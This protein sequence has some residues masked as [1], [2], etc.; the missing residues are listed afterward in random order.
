MVRGLSLVSV[1]LLAGLPGYGQIIFGGPGIGGGYPG[2]RYPQGG[3][4]GPNQQGQNNEQSTLVGTLRNLTE[5]NL[6]IEDDDKNVTVVTISGSTK[7]LTTS[8]AKTDSGDFQPGDRISIN[9]KQDDKTK[10]YKA[11]EISMVRVGT[12]DEHSLASL[13]TDDMAPLPRSSDSGSSSS[14]S[15]SN[16]SSS[17]SSNRPVLRRASGSDDNSSS[18]S[19]SSSSPG[20]DDP[21]RPRLRRASESSSSS[22]T[23]TASNAGS[24]SDSS[25]GP[26]RMRRAVS[27]SDDGSPRAEITPGDS[28]SS[29]SSTSRASSSSGSSASGSGSSDSDGPPRMRRGAPPPS[30]SDNTIAEVR[31]SLH[32]GDVNGTTQLPTEPQASPAPDRDAGGSARYRRYSGGDEVIDKAREAAFSF[33]ETLPNFIVKQYTTRYA[34]A[35][36]RGRGVS[37]QALDTVTADVIEED[38]HEKYKN[39]LVNGRA[40]QGADPER[41]GSWSTG[42]FSSMQLSVLLPETNAEFQNKRSVTINSRSSFRYDFSIEKAN[43]HWMLETE[44][45]KTEPAYSGSIWIDKETYRVLRIEQQ[46]QNLPSTFPTDQAENTVDYDFVPIGEG[47]YLLPTRAEMLGCSRGT[48]NCTRNVIEFRNYKKFSAD[49]NI[50]FGP[51]Q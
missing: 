31:P 40:S 17:G 38:G 9:A 1:L 12:P 2:R 41:T 21:D 4:N 28:S 49:T 47:K 32:A 37:W 34:T 29:S 33:A 39:I 5:K 25:S 8:G 46:A 35:P 42:E 13:H 3:P 30:D 50:T 23:T 26:P 22:D 44:G 20:D 7:Y 36:T 15:A 19:R 27:G 48:N 6:V 16:S 11:R 43:S 18:A 14:S 45:Q 51:D 10:A 24:S